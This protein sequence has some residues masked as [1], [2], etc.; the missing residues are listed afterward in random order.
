MP[1]DVIL[2][3]VGVSSGLDTAELRDVFLAHAGTLSPFTLARLAACNK[4]FQARIQLHIKVK[5]SRLIISDCSKLV[6]KVCLSTCAA[7][8][9]SMC[10]TS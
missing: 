1:I 2:G 7:A 9:S 8:N 10:W 4:D 3:P 5:Q 6:E